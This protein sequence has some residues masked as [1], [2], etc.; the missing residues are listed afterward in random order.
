MKKFEDPT[1]AGDVSYS[2]FVQAIDETFT[3]QV[4]EQETSPQ[5]QLR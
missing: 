5:E 1:N 2:A 3:G 4:V